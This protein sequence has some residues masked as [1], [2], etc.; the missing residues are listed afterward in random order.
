MVAGRLAR[1]VTHR[2]GGLKLPEQAYEGCTLSGW[3]VSPYTAKVRS[4]LAFKGV[5]F[6][7]SA[8]SSLKLWLQVHRSVGRAIMP[9]AQLSNGEWRQD[10]AL[11]CDEIEAEHPEPSTKPTSAAQQIASLLLERTRTRHV[12]PPR[13]ACAALH[14]SIT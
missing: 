14:Q 5:A 7:D 6:T 13:I 12:P 11:M 3:L 1:A 8:P 4:M 10:S 9:V 2:R